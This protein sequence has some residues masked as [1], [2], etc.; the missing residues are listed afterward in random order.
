MENAK[1][2]FERLDDGRFEWGKL[3]LMKFG[4]ISAKAVNTEQAVRKDVAQKGDVA[5]IYSFVRKAIIRYY[6]MMAMTVCW[7]V[8]LRIELFGHLRILCKLHEGHGQRLHIEI[9]FPFNRISN[10]ESE[11]GPNKSVH[12]QKSLR[13]SNE[14]HR[15]FTSCDA[16]HHNSTQRLCFIECRRKKSNAFAAIRI[17]IK[18]QFK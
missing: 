15:F 12:S 2:N 10:F 7:M 14:K 6:L 5:N 11:V 1:V 8:A 9:N 16:S 4:S 3:N 13:S 17:R 18:H